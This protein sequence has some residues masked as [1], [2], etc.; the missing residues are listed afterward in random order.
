M[1]DPTIPVPPA[2]N[3]IDPI[4]TNYNR[5]ILNL[6]YKASNLLKTF[7]FQKNKNKN[8]YI[9]KLNYIIELNEMLAYL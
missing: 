3:A 4:K 7:I 8:T 5:I 2:I 9:M 6:N 1:P